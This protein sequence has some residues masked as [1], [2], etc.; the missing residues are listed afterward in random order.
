MADVLTISMT[1]RNDPT[2][3]RLCLG[4]G[5]SLLVHVLVL[6]VQFRFPDA[7][8]VRQSSRLDVVLVNSKTQEKP[9]EASTLAQANLDGGGHVNEDRR[10]TAPVLAPSV[11]SEARQL[12]QTKQR[13]QALEAEQR[14]L[15]T[16]ANAASRT[17][18]PSASTSTPAQEPAPNVEGRDLRDAALSSMRLQAQVDQRI[19]AYQKRPRRQFIGARATEYRFAQYEAE[20]RAKIERIGTVNYPAEARGRLYGNLR[21]TVTLRPDGTI[22]SMELDRSSGLKILDDAAFRIVRMAA[23]FGAFP[24]DIRA[25]TDL[26][27]ITRTWFFGQGDRLWTETGDR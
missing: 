11:T 7:L 6:S 3:R 22:E 9:P 18:I 25:D 16:Q 4:L 21:M 13:A 24:P 15:L 17:P 5:V 12:A 26:L 27:V 14:R 23:P 19:E 1:T 20:W 2:F 10:T 8:R